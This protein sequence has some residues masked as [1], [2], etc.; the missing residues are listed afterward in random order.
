MDSHEL[1]DAA[2]L[3]DQQKQTC[4]RL[5]LPMPPKV[6]IAINRGVYDRVAEYALLD[7]KG[8]RPVL[9]ALELF[10][11]HVLDAEGRWQR[12]GAKSKGRWWDSL[13]LAYERYYNALNVSTG[14]MIEALEQN[15]LR[16]PTRQELGPQ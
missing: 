7:E 9:D 4:E 13:V 11:Q 6:L 14:V 16:P 8:V 1:R 5:G 10:S 3:G 2:I 12:H 15:G